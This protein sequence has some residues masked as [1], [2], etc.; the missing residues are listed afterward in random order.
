MSHDESTKQRNARRNREIL[1]TIANPETNPIRTLRVVDDGAIVVVA[2]DAIQS[3]KVLRAAFE[4]FL[5]AQNIPQ[6]H[7]PKV[8]AAIRLVREQGLTVAEAGR[9]VTGSGDIRSI[10]AR[11]DRALKTLK[12]RGQGGAL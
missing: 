12:R 10:R 9:I 8:S 6:R 3:R 11:I 1:E 2:I 7:S 4:K 5:T